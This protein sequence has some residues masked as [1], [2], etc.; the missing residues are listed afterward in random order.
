MCVE[1]LKT[2]PQGYVSKSYGQERRGK[3]KEPEAP[4]TTAL[5]YKPV[6]PIIHNMIQLHDEQTVLLWLA[7]GQK[8]VMGEEDLDTLLANTYKLPRDWVVDAY[9]QKV[10]GWI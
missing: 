1:S 4:S 3:T 8:H 7:G 5:L 9:T 10:S 2:A 6:K